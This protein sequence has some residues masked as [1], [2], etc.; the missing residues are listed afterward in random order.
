[1]KLAEWFGL[2]E[3][4]CRNCNDAEWVCEN[5]RDR[6]WDGMDNSSV[7]CGCGAGVPCPVC[8][9]VVR[10]LSPLPKPKLATVRNAPSRDE[11]AA[12]RQD[13]TTAFVMAALLRN[14]VECE[15][16]W[17]IDSWEAGK[18]DQRT[19]DGLRE[20][21]DALRGIAEADYEAFCETLGL[22]PEPLH[23]DAA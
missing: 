16:K 5:H 12:W 3:P 15:D 1:M 2:R 10:P 19:L 14:A 22:E 4:K 9:E 23:G 17:F 20:R 7:A 8:N 21:A 13:P 6:P 18:A 11:F